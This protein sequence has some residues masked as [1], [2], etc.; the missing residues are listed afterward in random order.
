MGEDKLAQA[1]WIVAAVGAVVILCAMT[2]SK[3]FAILHLLLLIGWYFA[4][5]K[6]QAAYVKKEL[7]EQYQ[8]KTWG[9]PIVIAIVAIVGFAFLSVILAA[10]LGLE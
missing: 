7:D 8:K 9:A 3:G 4:L 2:F 1:N 10:L 6:K 5:A